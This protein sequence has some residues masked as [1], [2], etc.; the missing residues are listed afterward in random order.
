VPSILNSII[1]RELSAPSCRR[2]LAADGVT[3]SYL[4]INA[5][6]GLFPAAS[7]DVR[8]A[9][10]SL[11][12]IGEA[13]SAAKNLDEYQYLICS[14]APSLPDSDPS[15]LSMQKYRIAIFAAFAK[16]VSIL[17]ANQGELGEWSRQARWLVE[18]TSEAYLKAKSGIQT[19]AV[20]RRELF[21]YFGVPEDA[22]DSAL[23]SYYGQQ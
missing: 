13:S 23:R 8:E 21:D 7:I 11:P 10:K 4:S 12:E 22:V 1:S 9:R 3:S 20:R 18:E 14:L 15:K 2:I 5:A 6:A 16:L 19:Y 17:G